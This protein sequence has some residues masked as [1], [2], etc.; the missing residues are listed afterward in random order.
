MADNKKFFTVREVSHIFG[1]SERTICRIVGEGFVSPRQDAGNKRYITD[2]DLDAV[3]TILVLSRELG[4]NWAGVEVIM[5]MRER[6]ITMQQHMNAIVDYL[7]KLNETA[8]SE[9]RATPSGQ[10]FPKAI[11][12]RENEE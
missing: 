8:L 12:V 10:D 6:M 9:G 1:V 3:R 11:I 7:N 5:H 4:V 2:N